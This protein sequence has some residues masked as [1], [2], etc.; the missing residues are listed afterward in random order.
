MQTRLLIS[1]IKKQYEKYLQYDADQLKKE[2]LD[3]GFE[4]R[5]HGDIDRLITR[6]FALARAAS[7]R[8][9]EM[10]HYDCQLAGGIA[11]CRGHVAEMRTG[12][13]KTLTAT[14]PMFVRALAGEGALLATSND[15]LAKRDA[16]WMKP[17]YNL[18]GLSIGVIQT[19]LLYTSPSPR[20]RG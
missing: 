14:L 8:E 2:T 13:G 15:Y 1:K 19:C 20:D 12:E 3:L 17:V 6:G 18:L 11:M 9:L 5:T 10:A 7:M 4:S 16:M